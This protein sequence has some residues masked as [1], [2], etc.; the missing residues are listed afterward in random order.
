MECKECGS[1]LKVSNSKYESPKNNTEVYNTLDLVCINP[2]CPSY[3][4]PNL[5]T[6]RKIAAKVKNKVG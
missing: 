6:P 2:K 4:G 3:A 1:D 5:N